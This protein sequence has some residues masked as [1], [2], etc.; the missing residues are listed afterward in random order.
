MK[1]NKTKLHIDR[2]TL[3]VLSAFDLPHAVGA[4][5]DTSI[6]SGLTVCITHINTLCTVISSLCTVP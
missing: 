4:S 6:N 5:D 2:Q 1:K 3:R